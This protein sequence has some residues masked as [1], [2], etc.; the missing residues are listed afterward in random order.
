[1]SYPPLKVEIINATGTIVK[2]IREFKW[3][4]IVLVK[5]ECKR[6]NQEIL[7]GSVFFAAFG[8][9]AVG[10]AFAPT[11][12]CRACGWFWQARFLVV[13]RIE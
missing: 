11:V 5:C 8:F 1:M 4:L 2:L 12:G 3:Y 7:R 10:R 9:S 13:F 6:V